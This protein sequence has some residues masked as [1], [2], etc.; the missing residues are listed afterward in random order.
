M[1][2]CFRATFVAPTSGVPIICSMW[3][4]GRAFDFQDGGEP[5]SF[6]SDAKEWTP[7]EE[8]WATI[9][10][11]SLERPAQV[12]ILGVQRSHPKMLLS[13]ARISIS[14]SQDAVEAPIFF[15]EVPLPFIDAVKDPSRI[16]WR[17]GSVAKREEPR[18]LLD[19]IPSCATVIRSARRQDVC[20][21][22]DFASDKGSYMISPVRK[23]MRFRKTKLLL[24][25]TMIGRTGRA[26]LG[27]WR[28]FRPTARTCC[29][30]SRIGRC[31]CRCRTWSIRSFSF[32]SRVF[33]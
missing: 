14:T 19:G 6:L 1:K 16:R 17:F 28:R 10:Q 11:R 15:R 9:K 18:L 33:W 21:D 20:D 22:V 2:P 30:W 13:G 23:R 3:I 12:S 29:A 25:A 7:C 32:R 24:G 5:M 31:F 27:F 8:D 4:A 26:R